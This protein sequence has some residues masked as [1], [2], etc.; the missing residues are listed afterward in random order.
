MRS[1][2]IAGLLLCSS[3]IACSDKEKGSASG[4]AKPMPPV[5]AEVYILRPASFQETIE[6]P[7]TLMAAESA[8]IHPESAGRIV[9]LNLA[10]G[11]AVPAGYLIAKIDDADLQAQLIKLQTQLELAEQTQSRQS[12]LLAL[13][14]ISQQ[15]YDLSVLQVRNLKADIGILRTAID[16]T[17]VRAPFAGKMG[18]KNIS[19]GAFVTSAS[20]ITT[21][22]QTQHLKVDFQLPEKYAQGLRTGATVQFRTGGSAGSFSAKVSAVAPGLTETNRSLNYRATVSAADGSLLPGAFA[23]VTIQLSE[24]PQALLLP[25]QAVIPQAKGKRVIRYQGG[26][27]EFVDITTGARTADQVEVLTG[28]AAGDTILVS[29]LM[30]VRPNSAV[31]IGKIQNATPPQ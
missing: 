8:E 4:P 18:L 7:G 21:L 10:E 27:A 12:K 23:T 13:Q 11:K 3:L 1:I 30:S 20:V 28:L 29:G 17:E 22:Q 26:K 5:K 31:Q 6:V 25:A 15:D 19:I 2:P 16:K 9:R 24:K 14:G